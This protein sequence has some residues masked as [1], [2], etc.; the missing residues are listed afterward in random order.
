MGGRGRDKDRVN[1]IYTTHGIP[2]TVTTM[3]RGRDKDRVT[4]IAAVIVFRDKMNGV[5]ISS[6][7]MAL[8]GFASY[9]YQNYLDDLK[10]R[11]ARGV[12]PKPRDE[13]SC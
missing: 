12:I 4:P 10:A 2:N 8:G 9:I 6:M 3:G 5:K 13:S 11:R 1:P 7:L